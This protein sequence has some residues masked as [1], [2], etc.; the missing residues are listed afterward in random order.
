MELFRKAAVM[1]A[2]PGDKDWTREHGFGLACDTL[3]P[4]A[5]RA[6][7]LKLKDDRAFWQQCADNERAQASQYDWKQAVQILDQVYQS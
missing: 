1:Q 6:A 4:E 7:V 3:D 5:I 2:E